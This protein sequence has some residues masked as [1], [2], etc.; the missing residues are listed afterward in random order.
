MDPGFD[1]TKTQNF[2]RMVQ[3]WGTIPLAYLEQL[4]RSDFM[5]GYIGT[6]DRTMYP[7]LPPGSFVQVDESKHR[8]ERDGWRSEYERP[9]YFVEGRE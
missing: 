6:G 3:E 1:P 2:T 5:Y 7:I 8:I 4:S 9:I